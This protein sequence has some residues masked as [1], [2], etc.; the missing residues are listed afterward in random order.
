MLLQSVGVDLRLR[1]PRLRINGRLLASTTASGLS[2]HRRGHSR[3]ILIRWPWADGNFEFLTNLGVFRLVLA[4]I[5]S[6]LAQHGIDEEATGGS[7]IKT[8]DIGSLVPA[9]RLADE[10]AV[11][12]L[13]LLPREL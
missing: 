2:S 13:C 5:P 9:A 11:R 7:F 6:C 4:D 8:E 3:R 12:Q 1:S 10:L